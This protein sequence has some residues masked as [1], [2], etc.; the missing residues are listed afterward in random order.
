MPKKS[1]DDNNDDDDDIPLNINFGKK[2]HS[3]PKQKPVSNSTPAKTP[4][5][6]S[7]PLPLA[8]TIQPLYNV[9]V[10]F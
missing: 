5:F 8:P 9:F 7:I 10:K 6:S 3:T 2:S 1:N 4:L